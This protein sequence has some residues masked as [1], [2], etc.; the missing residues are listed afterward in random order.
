MN[1]SLFAELRNIFAQYNVDARI[2]QHLLSQLQQQ[3]NTLETL[4]QTIDQLPQLVCRYDRHGNIEYSNAAFQNFFG[5]SATI[6]HE[7]QINDFIPIGM[8]EQ[9]S[10]RLDR[11]FQMPTT[12][13]SDVQLED[14]HGRIITYQW[15]ETSLLNANG[16]IVAIQGYGTE[17]GMR[18]LIPKILQ[19]TIENY[20]RIVQHLHGVFVLVFDLDLRFLLSDGTYLNGPG[21]VDLRTLE[22][23]SIFDVWSDTHLDIMHA[24][25]TDILDGHAQD[26]EYRDNGNTF[27][28]VGVPIQDLDGNVAY[29]VVLMIDISPQKRLQH[30]SKQQLSLIADHIDDILF[31]YNPLLNQVEYLS[32]AYHRSFDLTHN[33]TSTNPLWLIREVHPADRPKV[34]AFWREGRIFQDLA[35]LEVRLKPKIHTT[36]EHWILI[37]TFPVR[38]DENQVIRVVGIVKDITAQRQEDA[39]FISAELEQ[40]RI[41]IL[42]EFIDK[43]AHEFRT[44]LS[45][46]NTNA[47]LM[48]NTSEPERQQRYRQIIERQVQSISHL[49]ERLVLMAKLDGLQALKRHT[50]IL[51]GVVRELLAKVQHRIT[52]Q[53]VQLNLLLPEERIQLEADAHYLG[54]AITELVDNALKVLPVGG[55]LTV[56]LAMSDDWYVIMILDTGGGIEMEHIGHIFKRFYRADMAHTTKGFGLGLPIARRIIELH[57]GH[58][59]VESGKEGSRFTI[60]L[61]IQEIPDT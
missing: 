52:D 7:Q 35:F 17:V 59:T 40:E 57:G 48:T 43:A 6:T 25:Y 47:Y 50:V 10:T 61:P 51:Q 29:G 32:D 31:V 26:F 16:E 22:G 37:R 53:N 38:G 3:Q 42:T 19:G 55:T 28:V 41:R 2:Q 58:I 4:Q 44:P 13:V 14:I 56:Q 54:V 20:R 34:Y 5:L 23:K 27:N 21:R 60:F 15:T 36:E 33:P 11:L 8:P 1:T 49:V 30:Q 9:R 46:I 24:A 12:I 39:Q 18:D 45:I